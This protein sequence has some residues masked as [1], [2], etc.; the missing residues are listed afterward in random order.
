[1]YGSVPADVSVNAPP[2]TSAAE[3]WFH[4]FWFHASKSV[5]VVKFQAYGVV[6]L[7]YAIDGVQL[8]VS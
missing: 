7:V 1:M 4:A 6:E 8:A 5:G 2:V 3:S